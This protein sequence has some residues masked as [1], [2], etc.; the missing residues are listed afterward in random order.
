MAIVLSIQ[1]WRHYLLGQ[2]FIVQTNQC[3][4]KHLIDQQDIPPEF[5]KW[6]TKLLGYDSEI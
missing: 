5:Q 3:S 4:L 2:K 1:R 6:V